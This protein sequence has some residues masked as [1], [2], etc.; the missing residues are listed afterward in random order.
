VQRSS[1]VSLAFL[2]IAATSLAAQ[3][4]KPVSPAAPASKSK[5]TLEDAGLIFNIGAAPFKIEPYQAGIGIKL[6]WKDVRLRGLLDVVAS[7]ASDSFSAKTG[8]ALEF[9]RTPEPVS[10][11]IGVSAG[12]TYMNQA[13]AFSSV[14]LSAGALA[15]VEY[16]PLKFLS[17]FAEYSI[18]ADFTWTTDLASSLT[19]FDYLVD[20]R[21]GN[22]SKIGIVIYFQRLKD[23]LVDTKAKPK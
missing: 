22:D 11:Y 19:T 6:G 10:L 7:S 8:A 9:H 18:A 15:G 14:V 12:G 1:L 23:A 21:L 3:A 5:Q 2:L 17:L 4:A 16:F 13:S 20:T